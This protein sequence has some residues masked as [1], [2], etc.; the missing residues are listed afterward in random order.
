MALLEKIFG[1]KQKTVSQLS[2]VE[3][4]REEIILGKQRDRLFKKLEQVASEKQ[5]IFQQG[6]QQKT[7]EL[8]KSLAMN[9]ELKTQEQLMTAR[10][11]NLRTKEL[12]TVSR[13]RMMAESR[14]KGKN[15]GRLNLTETDVSRI[16]QW[17]D[18]DNVSQEMY[19]EKLDDLLAIG[20]SGD[21]DSLA[22]AGLT[23]AG[24]EL[25]DVWNQMDRGEVKQEQGFEQADQAVRQKASPQKEM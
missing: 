3:L 18:D 16:T 14:E 8:R 6:A 22:S 21:K 17:M 9:F 1:G 25:M 23:G 5:K 19:T 15:A 11:L 13:L 10:E 4:R 7:P 2:K 20:H 24:Q 12:M